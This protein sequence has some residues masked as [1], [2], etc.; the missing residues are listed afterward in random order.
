MS[1]TDII[2][3]E[4]QI[5]G[6]QTIAELGENDGIVEMLRAIQ[7]SEIHRCTVIFCG[8]INPV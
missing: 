5:M 4:Y 1:N 2:V 7:N 8:S 3:M 6:M